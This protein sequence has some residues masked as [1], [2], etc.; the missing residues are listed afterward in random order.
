MPLPDHVTKKEADNP[1]FWES[2][3]IVKALYSIQ[4]EAGWD[5][6]IWQFLPCRGS[7]T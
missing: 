3:C 1:G 2:F 5:V 4:I 6:L 7:Q